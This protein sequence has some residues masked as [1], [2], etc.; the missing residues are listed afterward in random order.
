MSDCVDN[1]ECH[2]L[3]SNRA[4]VL[5]QSESNLR[6][7]KRCS[8]DQFS[9][10]VVVVFAL[11]NFHHLGF[12]PQYFDLHSPRSC[13]VHYHIPLRMICIGDSDQNLPANPKA[14]RHHK[15]V[16]LGLECKDRLIA[17]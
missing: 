3:E 16:A 8:K 9:V 17:Q 11:A 5:T 2:Y 6:N 10:K 4:C 13:I 7:T 14:Y 1:S 12:Q 15:L